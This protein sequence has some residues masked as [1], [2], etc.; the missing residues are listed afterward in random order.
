MGDFKKLQDDMRDLQSSMQ[1]LEHL[2]MTVNVLFETVVNLKKMMDTFLAT[3]NTHQATTTTAIAASS[4]G[5]DS[6]VASLL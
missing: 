6:H 2:P 3:Q 4:G 5:L 1:K